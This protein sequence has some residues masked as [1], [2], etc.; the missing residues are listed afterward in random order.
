MDLIA[1]TRGYLKAEGYDVTLR[2]RDLLI[3]ARPGLADDTNYIYVWVPQ[4]DPNTFRSQERP[5]LA[6]FNEATE[7]QPSASKFML[8]PSLEGLSAEF[9]KAANQFYNVKVRIP[10]QFFN[11]PFRWEESSEITSAAKELRARGESANRR[12]APQPYSSGSERGDDLLDTLSSRLNSPAGANTAVHIVIGPAGMGKTHLFEA[13][14]ARL[15]S[16]FVQHTREQRLTRRP[17]PLLP[18]YMRVSEAPTIRTLLRAY[19][20]NDLA[21][22]IETTVFEWMMSNN[23]ALWLLDGL[24]E[25]IAQ[26]RTFFEY[27]EDLITRPESVGMPR[28]VLC[29][30]DSLLVTNDELRSFCA[31]YKDVVQ[32]Y[33]LEP[34]QR[35]SKT[36][37]STTRL[38]DQSSA[39]LAALNARPDLDSLSSSPFYLQLLAEQFEAGQLKAAYGEEEL[40]S[41]ALAGI[42]DREY[43]KGLLS[44]D[45]VSRNDILEYLEAL[46]YEDLEEGF[47]GIPVDEARSWAEL[48]LPSRLDEQQWDHLVANLTQL[49]LF[50]RGNLGTIR[51]S[52]EVLEHYLLALGLIRLFD[53]NASDALIRRVSIRAIPPD[54]VTLKVTAQHIRKSGRIRAML[55]LI[56]QAGD[57]PL[58]FKNLTQ[59]ALYASD[60][61]IIGQE[62]P[63]E[64]RDLSGIVFAGLDLTGVSFR[65]CDLTDAEFHNSVLRDVS[66]EDAILRNTGFF[67]DSE[68]VLAGARIGDLSRFYSIRVGRGSVISDHADVRRWFEKRTGHLISKTVEP[69]AAALQLRHVFNKLVYPNG[70]PRRDWLDERGM[71]SGKRFAKTEDVI[72]A[73]VRYGYLIRDEGRH[74]FGRPAGNLYSELVGFA[75]TMTMSPG[76]KELLADVCVSEN[77]PHVPLV[78]S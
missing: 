74:R 69:C 72:D 39:F 24:D 20:A 30:R 61:P 47:V 43:D 5:M 16:E 70:A 35:Q 15:Y 36:A 56:A 28:I 64:H 50:T 48:T 49:A 38:G 21:R 52:Q 59:V 65:G 14:F 6:K 46:A 78:G 45:V 54:W 58:A 7:T 13:L 53:A 34:W 42:I 33:E 60:G 9:R 26:D 17:F 71:R 73:C 62:I 41:D 75:T 51:F 4:V 12:R 68:L 77:C 31:E 76:I 11:T 10:I 37:F 19:L 1:L 66:L 27:F 63:F 18:E 2:G 32:I 67:G 57:R 25:L 8:V 40:L 55:P 3:G 23:L 22:P 29:V 44:A